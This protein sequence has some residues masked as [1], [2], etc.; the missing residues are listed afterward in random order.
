M[1]RFS[2]TLVLLGAA[3]MASTPITASASGSS[4][5]VMLQGT[6]ED[7]DNVLLIV[8]AVAVVLVGGVLIFKKSKS[9]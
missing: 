8:G 2:K 6:V 5:P 1:T 9:N 3:A 4:L 7:G